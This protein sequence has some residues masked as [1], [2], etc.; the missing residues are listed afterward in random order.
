[1]GNK[2]FTYEGKV[3]DQAKYSLIL[4]TKNPFANDKSVSMWLWNSDKEID[5][6]QAIFNYTTPSWV[7]LEF[8]GK[9]FTEVAK[10]NLIDEVLFPTKVNLLGR[11]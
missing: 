11:K 1:L 8:D 5:N 7:I 3:Y 2:K 9:T 10:G 4:N 6:I